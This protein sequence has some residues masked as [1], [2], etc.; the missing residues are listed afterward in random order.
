M[1]AERVRTGEGAL[2]RSAGSILTPKDGQC[3]RADG[4]RRGGGA[5][6]TDAR[7]IRTRENGGIGPAETAPRAREADRG[8]VSVPRTCQ[9]FCVRALVTVPPEGGSSRPAGAPCAPRNSDN[10]PQT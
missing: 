2:Y 4:F 9:D 1:R 8:L 6:C 10:Y 3:T 5:V 7:L